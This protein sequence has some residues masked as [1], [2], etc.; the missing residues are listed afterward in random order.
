MMRNLDPILWWKK[1]QKSKKEVKVNPK[2]AKIDRTH[3]TVCKIQYFESTVDWNLCRKCNNW[4]C[5]NCNEKKV[6]IGKIYIYMYRKQ[7][8]QR[9]SFVPLKDIAFSSHTENGA[10][11]YQ[12]RIIGRKKTPQTKFNHA[13]IAH[14][15]MNNCTRKCT[16]S[17]VAVQIA[18][19][20]VQRHTRP[21]H[22]CWKPIT[23]YE[24]FELQVQTRTFI[25]STAYYYY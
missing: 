11:H 23:N 14:Q 15:G 12:N 6:K 19:T 5:G 18:A 7:H 25:D 16:G 21:L 8:Q 13:F 2:T 24:V 1:K 4:S 9:I 17:S 10:K 22:N 3:C 20:W